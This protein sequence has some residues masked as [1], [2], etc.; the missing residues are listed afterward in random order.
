MHFNTLRYIKVEKKNPITQE[1][2]EIKYAYQTMNN[3]QN[4]MWLKTQKF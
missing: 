2:I 3:T 4:Y 1:Y